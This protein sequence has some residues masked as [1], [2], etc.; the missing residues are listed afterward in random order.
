MKLRVEEIDGNRVLIRRFIVQP[1]EKSAEVD[2]A[3]NLIL[4]DQQ[5]DISGK[6]AKKGKVVEGT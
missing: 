6:F 2:G 1:R 3:V 4:D 5:K